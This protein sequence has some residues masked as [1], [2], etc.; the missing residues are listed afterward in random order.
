VSGTVVIANALKGNTTLRTLNLYNNNADVDGARSIRDLLKVNNTL[1]FLDVGYNRLREKG[2]TAIADGISENRESKLRHLGLRYNFINDDGI[3]YLFNNAVL[4]DDSK[5]D[6]LYLMQNFFSDHKSLSLQAKVQESGKKIFVDGFH[7]LPFLTQSRLD[8]SI[9]ISPLLLAN[10]IN[11]EKVWKFFEHDV[12][13]G[14]VKS[15]RVRKGHNIPG[16]PKDNIYAVVEFEH[17]NSVPRSLRVAS[18][19]KAVIDGVRIRIYKAGTKTMMFI[20][21]KKKRI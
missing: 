11:P 9:W 18:K 20:K 10:C 5:L 8:Q 16:K 17:P 6:H 7:K 21:P 2:I 15:V 1:E 13:C 3:A 14:L 19:K 4:K 12:R